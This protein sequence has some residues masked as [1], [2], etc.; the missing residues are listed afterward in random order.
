MKKIKAFR[1]TD[2]TLYISRRFCWSR[3]LIKSEFRDDYRDVFPACIHWSYR[4][5]DRAFRTA[6]SFCSV[7]SWC[8]SLS[9]S[10]FRDAASC[11]A[12]S[13]RTIALSTSTCNS[14]LYVRTLTQYFWDNL[15]L[16]TFFLSC[17]EQ[18]LFGIT[19]QWIG[20]QTSLSAINLI[21]LLKCWLTGLCLIFQMCT[22][23]ECSVVWCEV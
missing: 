13:M 6:M 15:I 21:M 20:Q 1:H 2:V 3:R 5:R 10:D 8:E 16:Y 23:S 14:W 12:R 18:T 17:A 9:T 22:G 4:N 11:I 7:S 19:Y